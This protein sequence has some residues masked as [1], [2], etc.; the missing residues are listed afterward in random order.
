[1]SMPIAAFVLAAALASAEEAGTERPVRRVPGLGESAELYFSPDGKALVGTVKADGDTVHH[2]HVARLDGS[3]VRRI[4]DRGEDAC[5]YFFPD[6]ERIV[7]TSTRD[8][9][10]LPKGSFSDPNDY[11]QGAELYTSRPD[12]TEVKRLT[13]N[14][15]YDAEVSVSPDGQRILFTRQTD[16]RLDLWR[17]DTDGSSERRITDT[18]DWQEGGAFYLPDSRTILFRAWKRVDQ[19]RRGMPMSLF[20]IRDDGTERKQLTADDGVSWS[21]HPAPDG[22]HYVFVKMLPPHNF[23][24]FL[25]DLDT[26]EEKRLTFFEGFDGF[27]VLSPDGRMLAF[28]SSREARP[29][30]RKLYTYTMDV[31]SLDLGPKKR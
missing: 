11:P 10:D 4:N 21:P 6:G 30:E 8:H 25:G 3:A 24:I 31:S 26:K 19:A 17:M 22:R 5:S 13:T 27:P 12:G 28:A 29:G 14:A 16:G 23:E 20:T 9:P 7:W 1:M 18:D 2:V 15:V